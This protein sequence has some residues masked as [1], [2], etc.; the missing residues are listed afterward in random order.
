M[1]ASADPALLIQRK[2]IFITGASRSGTTL[3][4]FVLRN[5]REIL[6]LKELQYFGQ[7]WD[8]SQRRRFARSQSIAAAAALFACQ[9]QGILSWRIAPEHRQAATALVDEYGEAAADPA[10]LFAAAVHKLAAEAGKSIPCEQT[11]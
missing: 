11:P 4:S 8:P 10:V 7:V 3:L 5:H 1:S 2:L 9:E 6:G